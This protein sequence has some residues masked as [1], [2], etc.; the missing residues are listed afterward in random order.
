[1]K[2]NCIQIKEFDRIYSSGGNEI[3][4]LGE[5]GNTFISQKKFDELKT[6]VEKYNGL[7]KQKFKGFEISDDAL[8]VFKIGCDKIGE[9]IKST[10]Y[11]GLIQLKSGFQV[12]V[13]PKIEFMGGTNDKY[14]VNVFT[15]MLRSLKDFPFKVYNNANL[16]TTNTN[17]YEIFITMYINQVLRLVKYGIKSDY[18]RVEENQNF[19]K[20]KLLFNEQIKYNL[21]HSER[22]FIEYDE[23]LV[24]RPENKL[25]K[26]TLLK[27]LKLS[28]SNENIN[29]IRRLLLY[30]EN[31]NVSLNIDKDFSLVKNDRNMKDYE[32]ILIWTKVFLRNQSFISFEGNTG[33]LTLLFPMNTIFESYVAQRL[34]AIFANDNS[35]IE[36][37]CQ[38]RGKY[39][40]QENDRKLF[41]LRPD[42]VV[43]K[44]KVIIMDTKWK[45]LINNQ[46]ENYGISQADMYQMYAYSKEYDSSEVYVLYPYVKEFEH[47]NPI[48]FKNF[49]GNTLNIHI[50]FIEFSGDKNPIDNSIKKLY[51]DVFCVPK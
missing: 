15:Q 21:I 31:V 30:F 41:S 12:E 44:D 43:K 4:N 16:K 14:T 32:T 13:L 34:K 25:I 6:F 8:D 18:V 23:F 7:E 38:D 5:E 51:T 49:N 11:V 3:K 40:L 28:G 20:G 48:V 17:I 36:I 24:D 22:F 42:I 10:S 2:N 1:M 39:L 37:S 50:Y 27:L 46:R 35:K 29:L 47:V 19:I 9:Y 33:A 45:R 26:T